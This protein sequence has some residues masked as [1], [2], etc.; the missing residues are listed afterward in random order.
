MSDEHSK[1]RTPI[2]SAPPA[3]AL[4]P[5]HLP[6]GYTLNGKYVIKRLLGGGANGSVYEGE[7]AEIG[8]RVAIKVVHK[9]LALREDI[10]SRFRREARI[11]GTIRNRHVGQVYDV[12]ELPSGAPYMVMELQEG[13]SLANVL[14]EERRLPISTV[15]D[16]GRQLLTGLQAAHDTGAIHRDVKPDN[17]MLVRES[18]GETV[19]KLVD[20]GIGKSIHADIST[21]NVT[22]EG[23]VVGSPDYMPPEQLKGDNVDARVDVYAAGVV[24]YEMTT[25]SVPFNAG[26]LTE[27]FVAILRDPITPPSRLRN[28]CPA[29][30]EQVILRAT[31]RE[32]DLRYQTAAEMQRAL[33]NAQ[34]ASGVSH[35]GLRKLSQPPPAAQKRASASLE[36]YALET[37]RVRTAE[38]QAQTPMRRGG[39]RS[40]LIAGGALLLVGAGVV[41]GLLRPGSDARDEAHE[42]APREGKP[43][44][45][46]AAAAPQELPRVPEPADEAPA[47]AVAAPVPVIVGAP[48]TPAAGHVPQATAEEGAAL[49]P[50]GDTGS[51]AD[52]RRDR[53]AASKRRD[54]AEAVTQ[55]AADEG[56]TSVTARSPAEVA[57][58]APAA[59]PSAAEL[60]QQASAA[61]IQG[62]MPRAR[63]LYREATSK[64]AS[65]ADA[66]RGLGMVSSRMG[67]REEA[68]RAFERYL[69][70]RPTAPDAAAIQK[71]LDEL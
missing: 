4:D 62:Q 44:E 34:R 20:F 2:S 8:H 1:V 6:D 29:D 22:Q 18:S 67:Q 40:W 10:I 56:K 48:G 53:R 16:I 69:Q 50:S 63:S 41:L 7:H 37:A 36:G 28:D 43:A 19:V 17:I 57:T 47:A 26:T 66:W 13:R 70:L 51:D 3:A 61:F 11:C 38:L 54:A 45:P 58:P 49:E 60:V 14:E 21:R 52:D 64:T 27:L 24:L 35:D 5:A 33:E 42:V 55:S 32:A 12:G 9:N 46:A 39:A 23:M 25:G 65:N 71:K 68:K 59:G 31:E 15:I 30:L